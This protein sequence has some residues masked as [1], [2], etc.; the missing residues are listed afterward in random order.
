MTAVLVNAYR[1]C[2]LYTKTGTQSESMPQWH[3]RESIVENSRAANH[4]PSILRHRSLLLEPREEAGTGPSIVRHNE[5]QGHAMT[6]IPRN[7][8]DFKNDVAFMM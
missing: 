3:S 4:T 8:R 5:D 7:F 1:Y 6:H 2:L